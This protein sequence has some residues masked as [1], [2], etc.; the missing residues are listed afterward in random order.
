MIAADTQQLYSYDSFCKL[1][2]IHQSLINHVK[3]CYKIQSIPSLIERV[4]KLQSEDSVI[5]HSTQQPAPYGLSIN[6]LS[7]K[8]A[9]FPFP[10]P[11]FLHSYCDGQLSLD[12]DIYPSLSLQLLHVHIKKDQRIDLVK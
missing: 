9:L 12:T 1:I 3:L 8:S 7:L 5:V 2:Q 6:S 10:S 4:T 11:I